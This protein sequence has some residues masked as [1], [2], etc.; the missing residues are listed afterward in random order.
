MCFGT[1]IDYWGTYFESVHFPPVLRTFPFHGSGI[2]ELYGKIT[3]EFGYYSL[4]V[5]KSKKLNYIEDPRY[6]D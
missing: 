4:E 1:F 2:Y 6:S 5:V 3:E